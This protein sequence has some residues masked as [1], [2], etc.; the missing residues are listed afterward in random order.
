[1]T[2]LTDQ[3]HVTILDTV[4]DH[5][6]VVAGTLITDPVAASLTFALGGNALEDILNERPGL[7]VTTGHERGT[8]TGTLLTTR[9]TATDEADALLGKVLGTAVAVGE[10]GVTTINDD[11]ALLKVGQERLNELVDGLSSHNQEH[12]TAGTLQLSA[13]LLNGV[14]T[15]NG[16]A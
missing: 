3:L 12:D 14:S 2:Y 5:L 15:D 6:D 13:E 8:V 4:V 10:V 7:L 1:M 11:I 9:D 16:L